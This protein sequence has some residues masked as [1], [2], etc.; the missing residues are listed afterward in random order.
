MKK[1]LLSFPLLF[2]AIALLS[3]CSLPPAKQTF[4]SEGVSSDSANH[5]TDPSSE[6]TQIESAPSKITD[7]DFSCPKRNS[8]EEVIY[9]DLF[10][11]NNKVEIQI[12]VDREELQKIN[13]ETE[14]GGF[15][16]N[17][18]ETYHLAKR[19]ALTLHNG[20]KEFSWE[21]EN[22]GIRQ[23]GNTSRNPI[24]E[25]NGEV[26]SKNHF[27][28]SFDETFTDPS[29]YDASFVAAHGNEEYADREFLGLTGLDFKWNKVG[30][31]THLKEI[32]ANRLL[33]SAGI[34]A[35]N[36][37]LATVEMRYDE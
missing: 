28:I 6:S 11:L 37:G 27:K 36:V 17:K 24:F 22:V 31:S 21:V 8:K 16:T 29:M 30:D 19:F 15:S 18:P 2:L 34:L 10:N 9:K 1:N 4:S 13:D 20:D 7:P 35:Q 32:Y 5:L 3:S 14:Y 26:C 33:R 23:K 12:D 25:D